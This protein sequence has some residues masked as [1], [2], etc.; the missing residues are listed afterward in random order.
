MGGNHRGG[1]GSGG[2]GGGGGGG[3]PPVR[4]AVLSHRLLDTFKNNFSHRII[5]NPLAA[6]EFLAWDFIQLRQN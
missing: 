4:R 6:W 5:Q 3:P 2:G 1:G